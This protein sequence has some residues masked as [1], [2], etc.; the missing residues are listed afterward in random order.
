MSE[1][2]KTF[3]FKYSFLFITLIFAGILY[4]IKNYGVQDIEDNKDRVVYFVYGI[5]SSTLIGWL[6]AELCFLFELPDTLAC[7][8]GSCV[9]FI[10]ASAISSIALAFFKAK[11]KITEDIRISR[12]KIIKKHA[13]NTRKSGV[14]KNVSEG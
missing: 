12:D 8:V 13:K 14:K 4:A 7:A 5:G 11:A 1:Y 2:E 3:A 10:G 9:G 6:A